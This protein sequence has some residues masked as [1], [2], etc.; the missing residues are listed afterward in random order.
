MTVYYDLFQDGDNFGAASLTLAEVIEQVQDVAA[1]LQA[2]VDR[3]S[4]MATEL[5]S[6]A[7]LPVTY[8]GNY[9]SLSVEQA[10]EDD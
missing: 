4:T 5:A 2:D 1:G 3:F 8:D 6:I 10:D 7:F 9:L